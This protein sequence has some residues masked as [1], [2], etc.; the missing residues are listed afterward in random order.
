[1]QLR[2]PNLLPRAHPHLQV[3]SQWQE[4]RDHRAEDKVKTSF[5]LR[6]EVKT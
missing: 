1:M 4:G 2:D 3:P 5:I 6:A